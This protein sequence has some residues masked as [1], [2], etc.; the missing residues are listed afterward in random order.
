M[1]NTHRVQV[2]CMCF[3][4]GDGSTAASDVKCSF[5]TVGC[6]ALSRCPQPDCKR[7]IDAA[8]LRSLL[9]LT[10]WQAVLDVVS[11]AIALL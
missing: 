1:S 10:E 2:H 6:C 4:E 9:T 5:M 7:E 8:A 11:K 3:S